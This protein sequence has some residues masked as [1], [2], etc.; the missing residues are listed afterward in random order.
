MDLL[1][2][3]PTEEPLLGRVLRPPL[4]YRRRPDLRRHDRF[5]SPVA[6]SR[7]Q[8]GLRA[9]V[10]RRRV[11][12]PDARVERAPD[13]RAGEGRVVVERGV[14]PEPDDRAEP[15][16][17]DHP[18]SDRACRPAAKAAA[19]NHGSSACCRPMWLRGRFARRLA[20]AVDRDLDERPERRIRLEA[21]GPG[22][23]VR[24]EDQADGR[25]RVVGDP[26]VPFSQVGRRVAHGHDRAAAE[27][28]RRIRRLREREAAVTVLRAR[29][30]DPGTD[31]ADDHV[32]ALLLRP[33]ERRGDRDD[34]DVAVEARCDR[35]RRLD[36]LARLQEPERVGQRDRQ[37]AA[38]ELGVGGPDAGADPG[39]DR[40][41]LAVEPGA[42]D[43]HAL[44]VVGQRVALLHAPGRAL[45]SRVRERHHVGRRRRL[46]RQTAREVGVEDVEA[47]RAEPEVARLRVDEHGVTDLDRARLT[48]VGDA[49]RAV[50][51][52]PHEL[53]EPL[54][55]RR[56]GSPAERQRHVSSPWPRRRS[57]AS[58]P[59]SPRDPRPRCARRLCEC[60]PSRW[61]G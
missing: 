22:D 55:D 37:G 41:E 28:D 19:K 61:Q 45:P 38:A 7:A 6:E 36:Q 60:R 57:R 44:E 1:D 8:R 54:G 51:L 9:A 11:E 27:R 21:D 4:L 31:A 59:P 47:A 33:G 52:A 18:S 12:H 34:L 43:G 13:D 29:A 40:R 25:A 50:D 32:E 46:Q 20:P 58:R 35:D 15:P 16:L 3:D 24:T 56:H 26:P 10:H 2:L 49:R 48:R 14:R 30:D 17:L 23:L 53:V 42:D 39:H 5:R